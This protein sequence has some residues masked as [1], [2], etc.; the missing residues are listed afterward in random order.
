MSIPT[1]TTT[2]DEWA[3]AD[4]I[5][6]P[7]QAVVA[8]DDSREAGSAVRLAGALTI[9]GRIRPVLIGVDEA[10]AFAMTKPVSQV[11]AVTN[12]LPGNDG[13][14]K[15]VRA[16]RARAGAAWPAAIDWPVRVATGDAATEIDAAAKTE[17]AS[18][19]IAGLTR[20]GRT[21]RLLGLE[22]T[23]EVA[24]RDYASVLGVIQ[25]AEQIPHCIVVGTDF[26]QAAYRAAR[27]AARLL[28]PDGRMVLVYADAMVVYTSSEDCE[29]FGIIHD[30]GI[31]A[32]FAEIRRGL[33]LPRGATVEGRIVNSTPVK[34]IL[35][36]ARHE[37]A[38][39]I[40]VGRQYHSTGSRFLLGSTTTD[41]LR[42]AAF[43]VLVTP[44][45]PWLP[46]TTT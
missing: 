1:D 10:P 28:A 7:L 2:H 35:D 41:L 36:T 16:L 30:K 38:D 22:T 43:S 29:G 32:A 8:V 9:A 37:H 40:A 17:A 4:P 6:F 45:R 25:G 5:R 3:T 39:L 13:T 34:A 44:V 26:G 12:M 31:R 46:R 24:R 20:H 14:Q 21:V 19:V 18:L 11:G 42:E 15:Q 27:V 33:S 23:V